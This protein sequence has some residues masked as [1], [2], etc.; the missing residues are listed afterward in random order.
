MAVALSKNENVSTPSPRVTPSTLSDFSMY[1]NP[2]ITSLRSVLL[3][4]RSLILVCTTQ[5]CS[6]PRAELGSC[7]WLL[8]PFSCWPGDSAQSVLSPLETN[9]QELGTVEPGGKCQGEAGPEPW[10]PAASP[11]ISCTTH[12][13]LHLVCVTSWNST[14]GISG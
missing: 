3:S 1:H 14:T 6:P 13:G 4:T 11:T 8:P 7:S 10:H 2:S 9:L 12:K 5:D